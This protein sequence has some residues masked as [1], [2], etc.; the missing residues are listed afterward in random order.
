[1]SNSDDLKWYEWVLIFPFIP[2]FLIIGLIEESLKKKKRIAICALGE[3]LTGK[4]CWL[5]YL[6]TKEILK[7]YTQTG[8]NDFP[9][10]DLLL[11]NDRTIHIEAGTDIGGEK[12]NRSIFYKD[13]INKSDVICYFVDIKRFLDDFKYQ[14]KALGGIDLVADFIKDT[15][16]KSPKMPFIILSHSDELKDIKYSKEKAGEEFRGLLKGSKYKL[17]L[18]NIIFAN[19]MSEDSQKE[20]TELIFK[21]FTNDK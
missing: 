17:F 16:K 13:F 19:L 4:T 1:M 3:H 2:I 8:I 14:R 10:F 21:S 6:R 5:T 7:E 20:I 15:Q 9:P 11:E 18:K 12:E